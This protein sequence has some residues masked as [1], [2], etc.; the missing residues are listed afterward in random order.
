MNAQPLVRDKRPN[1]LAHKRSSV[2]SPPTSPD[3]QDTITKPTAVTLVNRLS[4]SVTGPPSRHHWK[5][6]SEVEH[7]EYIGCATSFGFFERRHHCRK[8]GDIFCSQHCSSYFRL[9]QDCQFHPN[10][11]LSR[12]CDTC[13]AEYSTWTKSLK[14][15]ID[16]P[17]TN[18]QQQQQQQQHQHPKKTSFPKRHPGGGMTRQTDDFEKDD[19]QPTTRH[20]ASSIKIN[21]KKKNNNDTVFTP[22]PSVPTDWQW[23]TF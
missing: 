22:V 17:L 10:G 4:S 8:C 20:I 16:L 21:H 23:S 14:H 19:D 7:C 6:D 11:I 2:I 3:I 5:S 13:T 12:G 15:H 18:E 1:Y 9:D